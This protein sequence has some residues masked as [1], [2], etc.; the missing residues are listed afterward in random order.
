MYVVATRL[1][2][3]N[4]PGMLGKLRTLASST[5]NVISSAVGALMFWRRPN[6]HFIREP[7]NGGFGN[8]S[9]NGS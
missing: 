1:D 9:Y 3:E 6:D 5:Y 2:D 7:L 4:Q 8:E